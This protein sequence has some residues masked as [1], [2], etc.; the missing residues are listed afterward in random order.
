LPIPVPSSRS[1][2]VTRA[3]GKLVL[4]IKLVAYMKP[5]KRKSC[6]ITC[7]PTWD[8]AAYREGE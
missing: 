7:L 3:F 1:I 5:A 2:P 4:S 8:N 6:Q